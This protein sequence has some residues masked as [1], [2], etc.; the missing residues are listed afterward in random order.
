VKLIVQPDAGAAPIVSAIR[1]AKKSIHIVIFRC[2]LDEVEQALAAAVKR[3]V[4]VSALIAHTNRGGDRKL[5]KLELRL[6]DQGVTVSRTEDDLVRYH[7]KLLI[8][9]RRAFVLGFNYTED[10][11]K[12]RSFGVM[13]ASHR[14]VKELLRLFDSDTNRTKYVPTVRDLVVSPENARRRLESFL[15]K[16]KKS[17]DIYDTHASD[18]RMLD[19]ILKRQD[20]GVKV[21]FI[22]ELEEKWADAG[23]NARAYAGKK[24]HV[25]AII[26][27]GQR[28]FVG[29]QSLR[30]LELDKRR[31]VGI[32]VRDL[33][34]V[35]KLERTFRRDWKEAKRGK[36]A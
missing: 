2:D 34:I 19:V 3:G 16:A 13:T 20:R 31:E 23:L 9:D 26:R 17:L 21:R 33:E 18:D 10:D 24:L 22:G 25:R 8:V 6:L 35:R 11:I 14:V 27:D 28:A 15:R 1:R 36:A 32:I 30:K 5:R 4:A 12:S 29:S 7:G